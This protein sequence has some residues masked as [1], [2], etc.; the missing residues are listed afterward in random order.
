MRT[1]QITAG[2]RIAAAGLAIAVLTLG[3][4]MWTGPD[5]GKIVENTAK[6]ADAVATGAKSSSPAE[7]GI[8]VTKSTVED[9]FNGA[10]TGVEQAASKGITIE[11]SGVTGSF[12]TGSGPESAPKGG[13]QEANQRD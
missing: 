2:N 6:I 8:A 5:S 13:T 4:T 3:F 7:P 10:S 9:S 1:S 12:N 11:G